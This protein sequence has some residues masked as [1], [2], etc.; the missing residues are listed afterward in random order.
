MSVWLVRPEGSP[1]ALRLYSAEEVLNGLREGHWLPSDE[2]KGPAD[3]DWRSIDTHP[4]FADR[5]EEI[6]APPR[7][8]EDETHLDMN[9]LIDV[10]LVLLI[11]FILTITYASLERAIDVPSLNPEKK[12]PTQIEYKD[13]K[14]Q[15]FVV[16]ARM[17][18]NQ[19]IVKIEDKEVS[20]AELGKEMKRIMDNTGRREMI[21][22]VDKAVPWGVIAT[23]LDAAKGNG[24]RNILNNRRG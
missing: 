7:L 16:R 18:G 5:I 9:P 1:H 14:D 12:G 20:L 22:D 13:I 4:Q 23:I 21:L 19:P 11:F 10:C 3:N 24:V 8:Q 15:V 6:L 2:V 17:N